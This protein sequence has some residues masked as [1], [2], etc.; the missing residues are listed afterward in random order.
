MNKKIRVYIAGKITGDDNFLEKFAETEKALSELGYEVFNPAKLNL[1]M[2][3]S[4]THEEYMNMCYAML[5]MSDEVYFLND[6]QKSV[7]ATMEH[8]YCIRHCKDRYYQDVNDVIKLSQQLG[9]DK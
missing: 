3:T 1:I 6:W 9:S 5:E 2:P 8:S 7:G 4:A